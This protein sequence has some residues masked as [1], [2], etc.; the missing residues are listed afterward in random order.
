MVFHVPVDENGVVKRV[1]LLVENLELETA[2]QDSDLG[3][4]C[5]VGGIE[6]PIVYS[7]RGREATAT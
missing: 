6:S 4:N 7:R 3:S 1:S 5:V 2:L